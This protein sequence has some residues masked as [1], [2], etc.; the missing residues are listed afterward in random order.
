MSLFF[1]PVSPDCLINLIINQLLFRVNKK[2][3]KKNGSLYVWTE[4]RPG[5]S[6]NYPRSSATQLRMPFSSIPLYEVDQSTLVGFFSIHD[7]ERMRGVQI[8]RNRRGH[9]QRAYRKPITARVV[10]SSR[11]WV[12]KGIKQHLVTGPVWSL[13]GV[14]GSR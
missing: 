5:L 1:P 8:I 14:R 12:G 4:R 13:K 7:I 9:M 11:G 10:D 6:L 2:F 3:D